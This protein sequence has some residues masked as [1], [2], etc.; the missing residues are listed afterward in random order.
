MYQAVSYLQI[1]HIL[2][3]KMLIFFLFLHEKY[4]VVTY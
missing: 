1:R 4:V 2:Q 3:L